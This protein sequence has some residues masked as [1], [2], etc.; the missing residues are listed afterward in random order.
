MTS[1]QTALGDRTT[2]VPG[3]PDTIPAGCYWWADPDG[4]AIIADARRRRA[5][6]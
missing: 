4:A 3:P 5:S 6:R 2:P 1:A